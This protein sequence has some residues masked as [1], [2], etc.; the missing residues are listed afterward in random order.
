V[1]LF[2]KKKKEH[3]IGTLTVADPEGGMASLLAEM[4]DKTEHEFSKFVAEHLQRIHEPGGYEREKKRADFMDLG[5]GRKYLAALDDIE[6]SIV[7][8][9]AIAETR[10]R[11]R[12]VAKVLTRWE[13]RGVHARPLVGLPP[14][15]TAVT[16]NGVT[17]TNFRDYRIRAEYSYWEVPELTRSVLDG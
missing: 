4:T 13:V 12:G 5:M 2:R 7:E 11:R 9:L 15:G 17:F 1:G 8:S 10:G 14:S 3:K 6:L 16:I